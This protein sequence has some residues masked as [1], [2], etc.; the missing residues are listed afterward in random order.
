[1][2][3]CVCV[4]S[5][6]KTPALKPLCTISVPFKILDSKTSCIYHD[7]QEYKV[8]LNAER[9]MAGESGKDAWVVTLSNGFET[10]G[11]ALSDSRAKNYRP[12]SAARH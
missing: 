8:K 10:L 6:S 11:S 1:M 3:V 2:S 5:S 12:L 9:L 4:K 7:Y